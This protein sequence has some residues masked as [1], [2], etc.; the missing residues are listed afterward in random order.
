[1]IATVV[2]MGLVVAT[3]GGRESD[4]KRVGGGTRY[5]LN[6]NTKHD[7]SYRS[8]YAACMRLRGYTG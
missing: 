1:M 4:K 7:E 2:V 5:G 3:W 6:E 8:A